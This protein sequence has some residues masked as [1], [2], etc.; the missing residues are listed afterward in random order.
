MLIEHPNDDTLRVSFSAS[1]NASEAQEWNESLKGALNGSE[2]IAHVD[3]TAMEMISSM[4]INV[5]VGLYK[6]MQRQGGTIDVV[7]NNEKMLHVFELFQ[8]HKLFE[9]RVMSAEGEG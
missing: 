9:V 6:V 2:T 1:P 8:L 7:V 4:G 3:L 5:I